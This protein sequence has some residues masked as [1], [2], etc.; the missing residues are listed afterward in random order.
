MSLFIGKKVQG[1]GTIVEEGPDQLVLPKDCIIAPVRLGCGRYALARTLCG[2]VGDVA[3]F[4]PIEIQRDLEL[5][6]RMPE[7]GAYD[8]ETGT[9]AVTIYRRD[10]SGSDT[11]VPH[12]LAVPCNKDQ[13]CTCACHVWEE[14]ATS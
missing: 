5:S 9:F 4:D 8:H 13:K 10:P 7:V 2:N 11:A 12:T 3:I 1:K 6:R 14:Q